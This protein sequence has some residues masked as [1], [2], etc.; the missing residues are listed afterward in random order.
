MTKKILLIIGILVIIGVA[1]F[2]IFSSKPALKE[3]ES[4]V[5]FSIRDFLPF[6][7][8]SNSET[9]SSTTNNETNEGEN[10]LL[11]T[12]TNQ[13]VPRLRK[14]SSEP[15]AGAVI[16]NVGSTSL[17]RFVEK[18]TGNV[19]EARSDSVAITRLTNTTIPKIVRAFWLPNAS[20]FL[21]QTLLPDSEMI[22]TNFVKLSK[23][24]ASTTNESL[25]PFSAIIGKLPT[26]IKEI[27]V[28]P[29]STKIFYYT[30]SSGSSDWFISNPDGTSSNLVLS[31]PLT[32]WLPKWISANQIIMQIKGSSETVGYSYSFDAQNKTLKKIGTEAVGLSVNVNADAS[33]SLVSSGGGIPVLHV[34]NNKDVSSV[35]K[36]DNVSSLAEKCVWL[37]DKNPSVICAVPDQIP[38]GNYP[39]IW[40]KGLVSTEDYIEKIDINNNVFYDISYLSSESGQKIDVVDLSIS[41]DETH[42]IFRNKIDGY[43]WMLRIEK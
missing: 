37:K 20:G 40:Y 32:E 26:G 11:S 36:A 10:N 31:H 29:D 14:I 3:G 17:V 4:R 27:A 5:G 28:K 33:L 18:G 41:P 13:P 43:L 22:E 16:F 42:L 39:D 24:T 21:A 1:A 9:T 8:S 38:K 6:G 12:P 19:Y 25:T 2:L 34:I 35:G 7:N 15:V 23:N 30:V